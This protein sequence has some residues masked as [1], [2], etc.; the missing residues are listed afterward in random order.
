MF[1]NVLYIGDFVVGGLDPNRSCKIS[2]ERLELM[3]GFR[4]L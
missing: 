1:K 2:M 4:G 3:I